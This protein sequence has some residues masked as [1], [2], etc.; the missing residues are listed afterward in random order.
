MV[1]G[2]GVDVHNQHV[3]QVR[4]LKTSVGAFIPMI[5]KESWRNHLI[6]NNKG[7]ALK[8]TSKQNVILFF[9]FNNEEFGT[10]T[11]EGGITYVEGGRWRHKKGKVEVDWDAINRISIHLK[12]LGL[13]A[14]QM[15][16]KRIIEYVAEQNE[17]SHD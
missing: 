17:G 3:L 6:M 1:V 5:T 10:F 16:S 2:I 15:D 13:S 7:D 11:K 8:R 9:R 12:S 14:S 4:K